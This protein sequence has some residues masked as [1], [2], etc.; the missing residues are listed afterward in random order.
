MIKACQQR[1]RHDIAFKLMQHLENYNELYNNRDIMLA[2][3]KMAT[4]TEPMDP[5]IAFHFYNQ[6]KLYEA[7]KPIKGIDASIYNHLFHMITHYPIKELLDI[8]NI[9]MIWL[10]MK[11]MYDLKV[12]PDEDCMK[13]ACI[14]QREGKAISRHNLNE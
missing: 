14:Y 3:I 8:D 6:L 1:R 10:L 4:Q 7:N 13:Q 11:D 2:F 12:L 5:K 9:D